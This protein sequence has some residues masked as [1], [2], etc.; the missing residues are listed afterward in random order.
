MVDDLPH[1]FSERDVVVGVLSW[2]RARRFAGQRG[3]AL[4]APVPP[5]QLPCTLWMGC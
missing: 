1:L 5:P 3:E 2:V 4:S